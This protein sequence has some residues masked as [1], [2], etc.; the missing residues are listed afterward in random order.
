[1]SNRTPFSVLISI[2]I[3]ADSNHF[4]EAM[5]SIWECQTLRPDEI[6]LIIDGDITPDLIAIK[7]K[8][9]AQIGGA[10]R[11]F[12]QAKA[13]GLSETY[14]R[15]L[16]YCTHDLILKVDADDIALPERFEK[17]VEFMNQNPDIAACG[18][19]IEEFSSDGS[20]PALIRTVP[21]TH[22]EI[23]KFA[24]SRSPITHPASIY[25]KQKAL[26]IGGYPESKKSEDYALWCT[27]LNAGLLL[28]NIPEVLVKMR[29][30]S[31]FYARRNLSTF[32]NDLDVL[33]HLKKIGFFSSY[34]YYRNVAVKGVF[35]ALPRFAKETAYRR[36]L[37]KCNPA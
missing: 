19:Y 26:E 36:L 29:V 21:T 2:Y 9:K 35:R 25:R 30:E 16:S 10:L 1:M 13:K 7:D 23:Y 20:H 34:E 8:W 31:D 24:K 15:G 6:V 27:M 28:A 22:D 14:N 33:R 17:Q 12:P 37:R 3:K 4:N 5:K 32:K 11:I 18:A